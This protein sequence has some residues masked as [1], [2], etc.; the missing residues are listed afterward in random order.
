MSEIVRDPREEKLPRWAR[1]LLA[2]ERFRASRAEHNLAEHL[3]TVEQSRIW[4]GDYGN[5]IYIPDDNGYQTVYFSPAGGRS[6]FQQIGVRIRDRAIEIQ[7][8]DTLTLE[9]QSSN[10]FRARLQGAS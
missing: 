10:V 4:Y 1:Q 2:Q 5:P 6:T 7:G 3:A 9:L 8:G